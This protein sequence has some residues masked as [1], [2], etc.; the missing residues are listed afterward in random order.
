MGNEHWAMRSE[1]WVV[2][3][4]MRDEMGLQV[5]RRAK[6]RATEQG[7]NFDSIDSISSILTLDWNWLNVT[8]QQQIQAR[9]KL[10]RACGH[11]GKRKKCHS[12][13]LSQL[14]AQYQWEVDHAKKRQRCLQDN[15]P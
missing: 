1:T 9:A 13:Q 11:K 6:R 7:I 14:Q 12:C 5:T 3:D 8:W 10:T 15:K 4:E 2:E